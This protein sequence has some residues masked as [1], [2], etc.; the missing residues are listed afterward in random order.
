M[1]RVSC[2]YYMGVDYEDETQK[3]GIW[4]GGDK[5]K[6]STESEREVFL[7]CGRVGSEVPQPG[8]LFSTWYT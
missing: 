1:L 8:A 7:S 5:M 3:L 2:H 6:N 4:C